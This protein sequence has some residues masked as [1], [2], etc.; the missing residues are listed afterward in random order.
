MQMEKK[1]A[2]THR[3][4]KKKKHHI[5]VKYHSY[6]DSIGVLKEYLMESTNIKRKR[7]LAKHGD[8]CIQR[9]E[10]S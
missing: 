1:I 2:R 6:N 4:A 7:N 5:R 8:N 9:D 3:K 10:V